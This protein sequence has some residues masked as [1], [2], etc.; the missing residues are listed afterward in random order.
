MFAAA[1]PARA[2]PAAAADDPF[3]RGRW[4]FEAEAVA[5]M[6]AWNYNISHEELYGLNQGI[7]FGLRDGLVLRAQQRFAYISQRAEDAVILGLAA[8]VRW[9]VAAHGRWTVFLQGDLGISYTAV[10][11][12]P[13]GTRFNYVAVG[14]GGG[15]VRVHPRIHLVSTLQ[16]IHISNAGLKGPSR[17]PDLEAIGPTLGVLI[18]F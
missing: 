18:R 5:A 9:R 15:M 14:G 12:P 7:T 11:T 17:N 1:A 2:Q 3:A 8:G 4:H 16:L 6:E 13:R 10:A